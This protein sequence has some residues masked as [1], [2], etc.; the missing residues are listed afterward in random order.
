[1]GIKFN[2][3][4]QK[5]QTYKNLLGVEQ[6]EFNENAMHKIGNILYFGSTRGL[7]SVDISQLSINR[8]AMFL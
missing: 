7:V 2:T 5:W 1:M 4:T 8:L 3:K 6:L